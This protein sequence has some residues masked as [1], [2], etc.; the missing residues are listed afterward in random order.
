MKTIHVRTKESTVHYRNDKIGAAIRM[1]ATLCGLSC[2]DRDISW[3]QAKVMK[4]AELIWFRNKGFKLCDDC[5]RRA[6]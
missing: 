1:Q 3:E 6:F 5:M 2:T 4:P